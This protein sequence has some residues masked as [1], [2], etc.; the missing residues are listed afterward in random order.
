MTCRERVVASVEQRDRLQSHI[1]NLLSEHGHLAGVAGA[2][3]GQR[4]E[5]FVASLRLSV[6]EVVHAVTADAPSQVHVLFLH[7]DALGMDGT[8][9]GVLEQPDDVRFA[10][11]LEGLERLRLESQ[12]VVH[13]DSDIPDQSLEWGPGKEHINGL[14]VALDLPQSDRSRLEAQ[15]TLFLHAAG[16]WRTLLDHLT[17]LVNLHGHLVGC[18]S[19]R[20]Y[21]RFGHSDGG[22][23]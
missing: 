23:L 19:L 15:L 21:L 9:V 17:G 4:E 12:L 10:G 22:F 11:F 5:H 2:T 18:L 1:G 13:V 8:Q 7:C 14:L 6:S 20:S 3:V 16:S